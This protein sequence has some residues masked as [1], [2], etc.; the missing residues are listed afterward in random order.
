MKLKIKIIIIAL[1]SILIFCLSLT[2][3]HAI[4]YGTVLV[5]GD[6][7]SLGYNTNNSGSDDAAHAW[8][9]LMADNL[10]ADGSSLSMDYI[11]MGATGFCADN[12]GRTF[13]TLL[14]DYVQKKEKMTN[15]SSVKWI[16]VM[17]GF[18][19]AT[20]SQCYPYD[21]TE[22]N[23]NY[24]KSAGA[25]FI[26]IARAHFPNAN[27]VIGSAG[28]DSERTWVQDNIN[29]ITTPAYKQFTKDF[30]AYYVDN[31]D[32]VLKENPDNYLSND[33]VHPSILG[34]EKLAKTISDFIY[35]KAK[36]STNGSVSGDYYKLTNPSSDNGV[37]FSNKNFPY[38]TGNDDADPHMVK[39]GDTYYVYVTGN[40]YYTTTDFKTWSGGKTAIKSNVP[41]DIQ[42]YWAPEVF[43]VGNYWYMISSF[44]KWGSGYPFSCD[45]VGYVGVSRTNNL[46]NGF[47]YIGMIDSKISTKATTVNCGDGTTWK[48]TNFIDG[49]IFKDEDGSYYFFYKAEFDQRIY[50]IKMEFSESG[51]RTLST[52]PTLILNK[53]GNNDSWGNGV[54][55]SPTVWKHHGYYSIMYASGNY[56]GD[57]GRSNIY[58][59]GYAWANAANPISNN[60]VNQSTTYKFPFFYGAHT[61]SVNGTYGG[62][63]YQNDGNNLLIYA[64][65]GGSIYEQSTDN[66]GNSSE[67]YF[68][69]HSAYHNSNNNYVG[70]RVNLQRMGTSNGAVYINGASNKIQPLISGTKYNNQKYSQLDEKDVT[71]TLPESQSQAI[72]LDGSIYD[73]SSGIP[74]WA[75]PIA[76]NVQEVTINLKNNRMDLSDIWLAS[77]GESFEGVAAIVYINESSGRP[78]YFT[79]DDMGSLPGGSMYKKLQLPDISTTE[80]TTKVEGGYKKV[81]IVFAKAINLTEVTPIRRGE[82]TYNAVTYT[83]D[84]DGNGGTTTATSREKS[85]GA[86]IGTLPE[87]PTR[88]GYTFIGWYT[89][90]TGGDKITSSTVVKG[91]AT[92]YA[93]WSINTYE[94]TVKPNGGIYNQSGSNSTYNLNYNATK[95]IEDP[96]RTGYT[97][98]GWDVSGTGATYTSSN[99]TFKMGSSNASLT[100]KWSINQYK[101]TINPNGGTYKGSSENTIVNSDYGSIIELDNPTRTGYTFAGWVA[102]NGSITNNKYTVGTQN[103]TIT[104]QWVKN[105]YDYIVYHKQMNLDGENYTTVAKDTE[106]GIK[107]YLE[108][109][110]PQTKQYK[111]FTAPSTQTIQIQE[112]ETKNIVNYLYTR[113]KYN[114]AVKYSEE[115]IITSSEYYEATID[116]TC[117]EKTGYNCNGFTANKGTIADLK[118]TV[119]DSNAEI[120]AKYSP[121]VYKINLEINGGTLKDNYDEYTIESEKIVIKEPVK[122]G[123]TFIGW[124]DVYSDKIEKKLVIDSHSTGNISYYA[125]WQK[126]EPDHAEPIIDDSS[127][128]VN[129][130]TGS[131]YPIILIPIAALAMLVI[132]KKTLH[133][134][135]YKL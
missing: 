81:R 60:W 8:P 53:N 73:A 115:D 18:N 67:W 110:T 24:L 104:A 45:S 101:I 126:N 77:G 23:I 63:Y 13:T 44:I 119:T 22:E 25:K 19:D 65:G 33:H 55:E 15:A 7:Y 121:I 42:Y 112:D 47:E 3:V 105:G 132:R 28:W 114:I 92:Y 130:E 14:E 27:I 72:V 100:A 107:N 49:S 11:R 134:K 39:D 94:L 131:Y 88:T 50:A 125:V 6:S 70:R 32:T 36:P 61:L 118:Y 62:I 106:S 10:K 40:K 43:K 97:F 1:Y 102:T 21:T 31:I 117:K 9:K 127:D 135:L 46:A 48:N 58:A 37:Y 123:Y 99:K 66:S 71:I 2:T 89:A 68:V 108:S 51:F 35:A 38:N 87:N 124:H 64:P 74:T 120:V 83:I 103:D 96:T 84:F 29:N 30:G 16:V 113:N 79:I 12:D 82:E 17:G 59:T 98:T 109:Y 34:Q 111:G 93:R 57:E 5:V 56:K 20:Q 133:K 41:S 129:P 116:L 85:Y 80:S 54:S 86:T 69:Y 4:D 52:E 95:T 78:Y 26:K 91:S 128:I 90:K 122:E 76:T 75:S